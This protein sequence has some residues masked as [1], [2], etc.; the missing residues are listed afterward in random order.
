MGAHPVTNQGLELGASFPADKP[1]VLTTET[2]SQ[3]LKKP[4]PLKKNAQGPCKNALKTLTHG[5]AQGIFPSGNRFAQKMGEDVSSLI[6]KGDTHT[7]KLSEFF[8]CLLQ[9]RTPSQW[10]KRHEKF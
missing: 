9:P 8:A 2:A 5:T 6:L 3:A 1:S 7:L 10:G 4:L